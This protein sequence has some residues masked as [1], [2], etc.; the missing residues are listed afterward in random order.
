MKISMHGKKTHIN[1]GFQGGGLDPLSPTPPG[2][3]S[4][5]YHCFLRRPIPV[6]LRKLITTCDFLSG[7][8]VK[9]PCPPSLDLAMIC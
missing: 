3:A 8:G 4:E 1:C 9:T 7:V 2:Y 5:P 6:L